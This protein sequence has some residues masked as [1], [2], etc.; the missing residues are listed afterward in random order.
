MFK[1]FKE[2][3]LDVSFYAACY[4]AGHDAKGIYN[5]H[6]ALNHEPVIALNPRSENP[7]STG[8]AKCVN[9]EGIPL[10]AAGIPMKRHHHDKK[11][12]RIYF[13]C[14][15]KRTSHENGQDIWK[16][17]TNECPLG[18]LCQP[19]TKSGPVVYV[20]SDQ[21]TRLYPH[22]ARDSEEYKKIMNTRTS[23]ERSNSA[24]KVAYHLERKPCRSSTHYLF[25]LYLISIVEHAKSWFFEDKKQFGNDF[26]KLADS[27]EVKI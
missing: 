15:V 18:V 13:H 12:N 19:D 14:P 23:C 10:C 3:L 21:D 4:D 16:A 5:Y 8:T 26:Q 2:N 22:I 24:K 7:K 11:R 17:H 6:L 25:R 27:L 20:R 1:M 9:K